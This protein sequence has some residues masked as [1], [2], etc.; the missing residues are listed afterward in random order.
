MQI[1]TR[2]E[3]LKNYKLYLFIETAVH[4]FFRDRGYLKAEVPVL[5][6]SLIPESY[7]EVFKTDFNFHST[8]K[9]L[10]LTP[11]P[12]LFLKRLLSAGIGNIYYLGQAFRNS[13]PNS[14][15]HQPEF[16]MLEFYKLGINY[17]QMADEVLEMLGYIQKKVKYKSKNLKFNRWERFSVTEAFSKFSGITGKEL[18]DERLFTERAKEKN[19]RI[20]GATYQ[21]LFSQIMVNEI[22]PNLGKNSWPTLIYDYPKQM[23]S[24]AKLGKDGRTAERCEFYINGLEIG[25]FCTELNDYHQQEKRFV[26]ES[27]ARKRN[28]MTD[29]AIDKGFIEA[30]KYGLPDCTGAGIGFERLAM[31]FADITSISDLKLIN[32]T[33]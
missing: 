9:E 15:W 29:H 31:V 20:E 33:I 27:E 28:K 12:E 16:T 24:L 19:Y 8:K 21:D 5:S 32:I 7:L 6:P 4:E 18:F 30:L 11:S 17:L 26:S 2:I 22:E 13:E 23:A 14:D 25:G 10:Y 1:K 3:N